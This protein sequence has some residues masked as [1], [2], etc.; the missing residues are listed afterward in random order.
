MA[1]RTGRA[2]KPPSPAPRKD[3]WH[4]RAESQPTTAS[5][6]LFSTLPFQNKNRSQDWACPALPVS[7]ICQSG[8]RLAVCPLGILGGHSPPSSVSLGEGLEPLQM[9]A[10]GVCM[11][12][13]VGCGGWGVRTSH[14]LQTVGLSGE[15]KADLR[16][17]PSGQGSRGGAGGARGAGGSRSPLSAVS[18]PLPHP[19]G[20]FCPWR[21]RLTTPPLSPPQKRAGG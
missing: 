16:V 15:G 2:S 4:P 18:E 13:R 21:G 11:C 6:G 7:P 8:C 17:S 9:G 5:S 3:L 20:G 1:G 14:K 10:R 19:C 12:V